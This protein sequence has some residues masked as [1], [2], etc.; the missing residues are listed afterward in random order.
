MRHFPILSYSLPA[1]TA[2]HQRG[3]VLVIAMIMLLILTLVGIAGL[4]DTQLQER[5]AGGAQDRELALQAAESALREAEESIKNGS[6]DDT[7]NGDHYKDY[8]TVGE[9]DKNDLQRKDSGGNF[10]TEA[11]YWRDHY[12]WTGDSGNNSTA[13]TTGGLAGLKQQPLYVIERLPRDYSAVPDSYN[14]NGGTY[15]KVDDYLITAKGT[16]A[17]DDA[18]V[19]LQSYYRDVN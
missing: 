17:T 12:D 5:M 8:E 11:E 14:V 6:A 13:A 3:A 16:G 2:R 18:V 9:D 4:R 7:D 10:V 1:A 19:I 15:P